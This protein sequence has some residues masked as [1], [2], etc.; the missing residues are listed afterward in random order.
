M[1]TT[2]KTRLGRAIDGNSRSV[3]PPDVPSAMVLY[4][5]PPPPRRTLPRRLL[6]V[7]GW[8]LATLLLLATGVAGGGYL[9]L[10]R[11][12]S[13]TAPRSVAVKR[14]A[15]RLDYVSPHEPAIAMVLGSDHRATD[16]GAAS[17]SD[18][19]MLI[20][21]DPLTNTV[22]LLSIPRDLYVQ[23]RCPGRPTW[24]GK[25]NAAYAECG[26]TGTLETV[27]ALTGLPVNYLVNV[28][29][30]GFMEL[31]D[32]LGGVWMDVDR[33][34][35]NKNTGA[36][37]D[38]YA[39]I[40]LQP[41]YQLLTGA[42][43]LSFVRYRH[44][45]SDLFRNARQQEFVKAVKEQLG[46]VSSLAIA[47]RLPKL[48]GALVHNTKVGEA[49]GRGVPT[50]T[51]L[52]YAFF[53]YHLPG[54]H[55]FQP[56]IQGL[57]G[58]SDLTT[59]QAH[60]DQAVQQFLHPD[61][62]APVAASRALGL[63]IRPPRKPARP[64]PPT[65]VFVTV[66]NGNGTPGAATA[67]ASALGQRGYRIVVAAGGR[68]A[69]APDGFN[70]ATTTV[71]YR[72]GRGPVKDAAHQIAELFDNAAVR[73]VT[74]TL[75]SLSA[76]PALVVVLGRTFTG[77][78]TTTA[79]PVRTQIVK[80]P[81]Y[82]RT[83]PAA[84][85]SLLLPLRRRVPFRLELPAVLERSSTPDTEEPIRRYTI[86]NGHQAVRLTFKLGTGVNEYWGIEET[87]WSDAP[88]L[89]ERNFTHLIHGRRFDLYYS[90][91]NLHMITLRENHAT[92][93]I[94]NSLL[95]SLS[96]ETMLAIAQ[97]LRPLAAPAGRTRERSSSRARIR[98]RR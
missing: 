60:I 85:R 38:N 79:P 13:A 23:I 64:V 68:A 1:R 93:W 29:F 78:L 33:R 15:R 12:V 3:L 62:A 53:L 66:L 6:R 52:N 87:D 31:V 75:M 22:S 35:Y 55:F 32:Q 84:T 88:I 10:Q 26:P 41:G 59:S 40:D 16:Q 92:Y 65:H 83:D 76:G 14:A 27:R 77:Q 81:A 63:K 91:A 69:N 25:I 11:S 37:Y 20:R 9:W 44:T 5:Q 50:S 74:R 70:H 73:P 4:R 51:V 39:N 21:T 28:N 61:V 49:G 48:V 47:W 86:S 80:Q 95:D 2:L 97:G 58:Y 18:T 56:R 45:D 89:G 24:S 54:G 19:I 34:Y 36:Y 82:V 7:F 98:R 46:R 8:L 94:V 42:Q 72:P 71:Y 96:N 30:R 43:A 17:R 57:T 67:A 90:G